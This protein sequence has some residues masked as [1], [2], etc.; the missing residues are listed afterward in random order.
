M[1]KR[2]GKKCSNALALYEQ[3][4]TWKT[5]KVKKEKTEGE[6]EATGRDYLVFRRCHRLL[7]HSFVQH[8]GKIMDEAALGEI[9]VAMEE[10]EQEEEQEEERE[11]AG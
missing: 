2:S 10:E 5:T 9:V 8:C 6:E 7:Q 11:L 4:C 3:A 1:I